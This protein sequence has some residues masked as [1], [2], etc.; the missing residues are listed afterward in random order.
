MINGIDWRVVFLYS[1]IIVEDDCMQRKILKKMLLST[2]EFMKIYE[3]DSEITALDIIENHNI[4]MFLIDIGLKE[5]SGLDLA[6][7]IR[8]I[9]KYEFRQIIFLTTHME[10]ITQ[11]FKQTHCYDYILKPYNQKVVQA[12]LNKLILHENSNL[13]NES[14]STEK[15]KVREVVINLKNGIYV[16]IKINDI[17]FIEVMGKNCE[18]NTINGTYVASNVS[19]KKMIQ[20]INCEY[21]IQSHRAF[22]INKNYIS[23]IEK[24]DA[25]L[26]NVY[27]TKYSK[28]A[29]LGYK[30]KDNVM[31]EFRKGKVIIC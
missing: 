12:M 21:I 22:A 14:D 18:V 8:N 10:Y 17:V 20:L 3:A 23:K 2:C 30:F 29:L 9:P 5:S 15:D 27:F 7:K 19:L 26:S 16:G 24:L 6:M 1:I 28:T 4:N 31:S 11:A 25:K 13:K